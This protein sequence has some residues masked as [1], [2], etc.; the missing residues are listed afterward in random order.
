MESQEKISCTPG[1]ENSAPGTCPEGAHHGHDPCPCQRHAFCH[2]C[3]GQRHGQRHGQCPEQR[4]KPDEPNDLA[5]L[6][7]L[8]VC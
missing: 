5:K 6:P 2:P 7:K 8:G 1:C 4:Q 3:H